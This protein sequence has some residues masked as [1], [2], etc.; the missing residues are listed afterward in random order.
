MPWI[1]WQ[2]SASL[3]SIS[4]HSARDLVTTGQVKYAYF[5]RS[6]HGAGSHTPNWQINGSWTSSQRITSMM[7]AKNKNWE[8]ESPMASESPRI[9]QRDSQVRMRER[10]I[11]HPMEAKKHQTPCR[12]DRPCGQKKDA[13]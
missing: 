9:A 12:A 2:Q 7:L 5:L 4:S 1:S 10:K 3:H 8:H 13:E 6:F 11:Q